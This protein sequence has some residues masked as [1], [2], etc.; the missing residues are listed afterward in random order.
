MASALNVYVGLV[1]GGAPAP[2]VWSSSCWT[3]S[4][5]GSVIRR[6]ARGSLVSGGSAAN[7]TA[8]ACARE[9]LLG[10]DERSRRRLHVRPGPL[11]DRARRAAARLPAPT[12]CASCRPTASTGC[13][14]RRSRPRSTRTPEPA[15]SRCSWP[16]P[17]A[18]PTPARSTRCPELAEVCRERGRLAARRRRL[19][20]LRRAHRAGPRAARRSRSGRLGHPRP[21]QV[22]LPALRVRL[23][24]RPRRRAAAPRLRGRA[25]L[26]AATRAPARTRSTSRTLVFSRAAASAR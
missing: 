25:G 16:P 7:I 6:D 9:S 4:S 12:S 20:R 1:D 3:G 2:A 11:L 19:R 22:A 10:A 8:L 24:A 17:P 13:R 15:V 5:A 23:A 26:P 18:R 14:R 21:A